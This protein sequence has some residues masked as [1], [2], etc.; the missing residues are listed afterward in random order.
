MIYSD[1]IVQKPWGHEYLCYRNEVLAIWFLHIGHGRRT[2][3]HCHPNK[4]TGFVVLDGTVN[5]QFLRGEIQLTGLDKIHIFRARFHS[6][7]AVSDKGAYILEIE[8]PEDK[9]DLVRLEDA[10]GREGQQYEG[11]EHHTAKPPDALWIPE[12]DSPVNKLADVCGCMIEHLAIRQQSELL[13]YSEGD[14][15]VVARGGLTSGADAQILWPGDVVDGLSL[16]RLA[17]TFVVLPNTTLLHIT[18]IS[19]AR[20]VDVVGS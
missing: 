12:P 18:K 13:G 2:S 17:S 20:P 14:I 4:H 9:H 7:E 10:Y 6:T 1:V 5:L 8:T 19:Q 16:N 15:F 11:E 3:L